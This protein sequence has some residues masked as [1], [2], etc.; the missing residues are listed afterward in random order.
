M[1]ARGSGTLNFFRQLGGVFGISALVVTIEQRTQYHL[2]AL[3]ATQTAANSTS[4]ELLS[5]IKQLLGEAGVV[6][7]MQDASAIRFLND[8]VTAQARTLAFQDAAMGIAV[9]F[10][11]TVLPASLL[12]K[13]KTTA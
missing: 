2:E 11:L 9:V 3:A 4:R 1:L 6:Q 13:A 5:T 7:S 12:A 10:F 8:V